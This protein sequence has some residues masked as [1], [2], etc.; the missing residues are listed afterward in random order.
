MRT[1]DG[2]LIWALLNTMFD[3]I[4]GKITKA[5]VI[6][7]DITERKRTEEALQTALQRLYALFAGMQ[8]S[9]LLVGEGRIEMANQAFCDYFG[10]QESPG[11]LVGLTPRQLIDKIKNAYLQPDEQVRRIWEIARGGQPVIGEEISMRDGRTC[12]RDFIPIYVDG[13]SYGLL[14]QHIDMTERKEKEERIAKLTRLYAALSRVNEAIVRVRDESSLYDEVCQILS[15]EGNFPLVWIGRAEQKQIVPAAWYGAA[16]GYL[17]EIKVETE[18]HFGQGPTGTS[19][20]ENRAVI[21]DDFATSPALSPW[22]ETATRFGF[23]SSA[24]F[25]LA[26]GGEAIASLTLY[27]SVPGAF[28]AEQVRLL[29]S[30]SAD[31]SYALDALSQ[32]RLRRV[33][34]EAVRKS[35]ERFRLLSSTAG[36]LLR[37]DEPQAIVEDLCRDVMAYLDCQAFFNFLV[38]EKAGRLRLNACVGI[39]EEE[40][41]AIE[42]LDYGVAVCGC[43]A[44]ARQ[45]IIAEDILHT[46][47]VRTDLVKSYGI[48]AYCCHPLM[49][50]D[51]LIGTLSFGTKTRTHFN[52]EEVELMR[53]VTDQVAV[54]MERKRAEDALRRLNEELEQRVS[55]RTAELWAASLY[56]RSLIEASLDPL[57]TISPEG[58][59]TDVNEATER[60]TGRN[61]SELIG[62]EFSDYFTE[63]DAAQAGYR[64]VLTEGQVR[65]YPLTIRDASGNTADVLYN[66]T[67]YRNAQGEVQGVFAAARDVTETKRFEAELVRHREHLEDMVKERTAELEAA[68]RELE[69]FSYSVS[70][71][72]RAPLR[73]IDGYAR[74]I[75]KKDGDKFDEETMRKF[76][77]IRSSSQM[78]GQLIDDILTLSRVVKKHLSTSQLE[79]DAVIREVWKEL[80]TI[81]P[82]R[83]MKLTVQDVPAAY[84]DRTLIKQVY[85]NLLSNAVKFTKD[86]DPALI[87]T[88]GYVEENENVYYI[89][90]NGVGFE[91]EYYDK[92]FGIFQRL[93]KAEEFDGT[94]V[95]LAIV[96]RIV[97]RHGGRAWAEGKVNEGATFYFT[98]PQK[99]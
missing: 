61:R 49:A 35:E 16:S 82:E 58:K 73:A 76:N 51:H 18:G 21:N 94:G 75:L 25:P 40:A 19:I 95:G 24:A 74:M 68:N 96:Q 78:M 34:D 89:K 91:M 69:S 77:V 8:S 27:S 56:S 90:D 12:L 84:G 97:Q 79:M 9:L 83:N 22:R 53:T 66:A 5:T 88:G 70:H 32:D 45:R 20:R 6:A 72:L 93:H 28:D 3:R 30:L 81:N 59:V 1:K 23:R 39:S 55:E 26:R 42:W 65:D 33:A 43:V 29:E 80:E 38:D 99:R 85:V 15:E 14:W 44:Q 64:K 13:K 52:P 63:P 10:L 54:A 2:R 60:V 31:I 48:Q 11:D 41:R 50:Q 62:T 87:E 57:V 71:D 36:R 47:D 98:L 4:D 17:K 86:R 37:A 67:V 46:P 92:L 7:H